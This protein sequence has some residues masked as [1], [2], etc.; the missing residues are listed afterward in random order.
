M[1]VET[2]A[3]V[4]PVGIV[5]VMLIGTGTAFLFSGGEPEAEPAQ[6]EPVPLPDEP[7]Q[8]VPVPLPEDDAA[9]PAPAPSAPLAEYDVAQ[10]MTTPPAPSAPPAE[11]EMPQ[12]MPAPVAAQPAPVSYEVEPEYIEGS[13]FNYRE[14]YGTTYE[15]KDIP[16]EHTVRSDYNGPVI[17]D[18]GKYA[19]R[20]PIPSDAFQSGG[21][22]YRKSLIPSSAD[23][24]E[25]GRNGS[26]R[27]YSDYNGPYIDN[28]GQIKRVGSS[29][30]SRRT[31]KGASRRLTRRRKQ[32]KSRTRQ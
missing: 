2:L 27:M 18:A 32:K 17:N 15:A 22:W 1:K 23:L 13:E 29:R 16:P 11:Y 20:G 19:W 28:D 9:P 10:P 21:K 31:K 7:A 24:S 25:D 3:V 6:A 14:F 30:R 4:V 8:A 5:G 26:R 12:P